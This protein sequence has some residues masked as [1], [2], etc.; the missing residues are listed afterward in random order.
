MA[1][2]EAATEISKLGALQL[3]LGLPQ[4]C[5]PKGVPVPQRGLGAVDPGAR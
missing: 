5:S 4:V 3:V 1:L 2:T